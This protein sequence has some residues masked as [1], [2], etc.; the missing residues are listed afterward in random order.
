MLGRNP[1]TK[2]EDNQTK[3]ANST[4]RTGVVRGLF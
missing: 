4:V 3:Q 2:D 1:E